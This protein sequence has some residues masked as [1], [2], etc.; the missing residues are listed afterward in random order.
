MGENTWMTKNDFD[1]RTFAMDFNNISGG[2][3]IHK[4]RKFDYI[5]TLR[6]IKVVDGGSGYTNRKLIVIQ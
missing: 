5:K 4:F 1:N 6:S 2:Q 3:G